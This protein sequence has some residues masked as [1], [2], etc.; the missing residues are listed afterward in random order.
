MEVGAVTPTSPSHPLERVCDG[1]NSSVGEIDYWSVFERDHLSQPLSSDARMTGGMYLQTDPVDGALLETIVR[2]F[3]AGI[4]A[5]LPHVLLGI[6]FLVVAVTSI[7]VLLAIARALLERVYPD[8][9]DLIVDLVVSVV[10]VFLW[11][12]AALSFLEIVGLG[13]IAVS[14]GTASGFIALGVVFA[15]KEMIADTVAGVYLLRDPDFNPGD[16]VDTASITGTVTDIGLRKTRIRTE[17]GALVVLS[18][19]DVEKKW[20]NQSSTDG[21]AAE[22]PSITS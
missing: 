21:D 22:H 12:G 3:F 4:A 13:D 14:L 6:V 9:Q 20:T 15:V 16:V 17:D 2:E 7:K 11:F 10:G 1:D 8:D 19:R 18:N 5:A